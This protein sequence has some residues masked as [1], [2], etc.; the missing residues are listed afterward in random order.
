MSDRPAQPTLSVR[1][2]E[3]AY[4]VRGRE[5]TVLRDLSFDIGHGE[6]FG[7]VG[8]SGCG[9]STA[10][11]T[12]VRHLAS[13]ARVRQGE[14]FLSGEN[15]LKMSG[16]RLQE[17]RAKVISMVY[18]EPGRALNPSMRIER[19]ITEVY[20]LT[21]LS[22]DGAR[23]AAADMLR[24]VQIAAPERIFGSYPHELSGGMQQRVVIA[25]A[26]ATNPSLLIL[27]EPTT[28]LDATVGAE[29]LDIVEG[30]RRELG[31]SVLMI[32]HNLALVSQ[33]CDRVGVLYA[34][35]LVDQGPSSQVFSNPNH[36]YTAALLKCSP[37]STTAKDGKPLV[38]IPG[39]LPKLGEALVG[40]PY[41]DRCSLVDERC[42]IEEP[43]TEFFGKRMFRCFHHDR[44]QQASGGDDATLIHRSGGIDYLE[45]PLLQVSN[46]SKTY[47][48]GSG[49]FKAVD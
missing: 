12:I 48:S 26:L 45:P 6:S 1:G 3:V 36:P 38:S 17:V 32:S 34:G 4:R 14:V 28:A 20:R 42:R 7:L 33:M 5:H 40:C 27:D 15:V 49:S 13:N 47:Q 46:A 43:P 9:K 41:S 23:D 21:G 16:S 30:L 29:V 11:M 44:A 22:Q 10:A 35:L 39:N 18:Q 25:M 8:E 37:D 2:L 24:R 31:T 19:Q